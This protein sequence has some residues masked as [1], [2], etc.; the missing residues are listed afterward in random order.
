MTTIVLRILHYFP[1]SICAGYFNFYFF[2]LFV[3]LEHEN[4]KKFN[5]DLT[6]LNTL[7]IFTDLTTRTILKDQKNYGVYKCRILL[8]RDY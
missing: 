7:I 3:D 6:T 1:M 2:Q 4:H 5:S 8:K